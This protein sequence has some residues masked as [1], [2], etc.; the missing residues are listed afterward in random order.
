MAARLTQ[1]DAVALMAIMEGDLQKLSRNPLIKLSS[2]VL[3]N[4]A[5]RLVKRG[6]AER[7]G[8]SYKITEE[9]RAALKKWAG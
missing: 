9:G 7:K 2:S 5:S 6:L 8:D 1:L 3:E 4:T